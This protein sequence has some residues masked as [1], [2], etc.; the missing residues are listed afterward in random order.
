[1]SI[2]KKTNRSQ[3]NEQMSEILAQYPDG[4]RAIILRKKISER[5]PSIKTHSI[6]AE[7]SDLTNKH[8]KTF[9][10]NIEKGKGVFYSLAKSDSTSTE[11]VRE[12]N[13]PNIISRN[14]R[15]TLKE[16]DLYAPFA[17]YLEISSARSGSNDDDYQPLDECSVAIPWGDEGGKSPLGKWATPDVIGVFRPRRSAPVQFP[18]EIV[19]AEIK[20]SDIFTG[21][22]QACSYLLFSHKVYLVVPEN[23]SSSM[24]RIEAMCHLIGLGLVVFNPNK[25]P[26]PSIFSVRLR[27]R[28]KEP[29]TYYVNQ[30]ITEDISTKLYRE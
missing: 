21:F 19:S 17:K 29:D 22:G 24:A 3:I 26:D 7:I 27:A 20:I 16:S 30:A 6:G 1:M 4:L 25:K 12:Q 11:N 8:P 15:N 10:R 14:T 13:A 18:H 9:V 23:D 2:K 28:K 5:L